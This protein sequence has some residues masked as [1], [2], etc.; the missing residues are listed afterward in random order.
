ML[1]FALEPARRPKETLLLLITLA[2]TF[3]KELIWETYQE[4]FE[5]LKTRF[6]ASAYLRHM[7]QP[8]IAGLH[9]ANRVEQFFKQNPFPGAKKEISQGKIINLAPTGTNFTITMLNSK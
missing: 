4:K 1:A 2:N 6:R 3:A 5:E 7:T 8:I 9:D